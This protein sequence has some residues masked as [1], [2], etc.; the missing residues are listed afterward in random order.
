MRIKSTPENLGLDT[1]QQYTGYLDIEDEEKHFFFWTFESRN[2]PTN[3]P[4]ILWL[5]G[6]PGCSSSMGLFFELGPSSIDKD[7]KPVFNPYSWNNNAT[8]IFLDQPANTGYSYTEK[9]VSDT[10]A[11]GKDVYAFWNCFSNNFHNM[12]S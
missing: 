11:A 7:I 5:T 4:V 6:G 10:V 12:P 9:P 1:V 3:D 2:D 8:V